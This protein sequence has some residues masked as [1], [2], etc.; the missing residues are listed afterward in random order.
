MEKKNITHGIWGFLKTRGRIWLLLGGALAG[1]FL[2]VLGGSL[3]SEEASETPSYTEDLSALQTY[4][5]TLEKELEGLCG[6]VA[7]VGQVEVMVRL[8]RGTRV[9]YATDSNGSPG[10]VGSGSGEQ[11]LYE[12]LLTPEVAG[13]GIV[14]RG[15]DNPKIQQTLTDLVATALNISSNRVSVAGK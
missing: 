12:T 14:C 10:S 5:E 6:S 1:L 9:L 2:I 11:A 7:G 3:R 8:A 4:E 15:G 13:V